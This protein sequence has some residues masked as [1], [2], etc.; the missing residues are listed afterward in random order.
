MKQFIRSVKVEGYTLNVYPLNKTDHLGKEMMGYEFLNKNGDI[1]FAGEDF[2]C[3]PMHSIDSDECLKGILG[4][5]TLR[6]GDTDKEYFS[7]YTEEQMD[8]ACSTDAEIIASIVHDK[9]ALLE[10]V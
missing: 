6:P 10:D 1:L 9:Y 8:F 3:S 4:F 5:L 2:A 7:E